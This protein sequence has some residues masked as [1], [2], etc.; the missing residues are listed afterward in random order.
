MLPPPSLLKPQRCCMKDWSTWT[1]IPPTDLWTGLHIISVTSSSGGAGKNGKKGLGTSLWESGNH[2]WELAIIYYTKLVRPSADI[3]IKVYQS[4][5]FVPLFFR[6]GR[7]DKNFTWYS[8]GYRISSFNNLKIQRM[9]HKS[10]LVSVQVM[11][12]M[13]A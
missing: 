3:K 12:Y 2:I 9:K 7:I 8:M 6:T 13:S 1:F 4:P 5:R 11:L 10:D